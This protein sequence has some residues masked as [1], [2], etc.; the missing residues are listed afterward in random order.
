MQVTIP[1][2]ERMTLQEDSG[3]TTIFFSTVLRQNISGRSVC[4]MNLIEGHEMPR[5][6]PRPS[7]YDTTN[8]VLVRSLKT[9]LSECFG[10]QIVLDESTAEAFLDVNDGQV[11]ISSTTNLIADG[12]KIQN[13]YVRVCHARKNPL[14]TPCRISPRTVAAALVQVFNLSHVLDQETRDLLQ[15]YQPLDLGKTAL[16]AAATAPASTPDLQAANSDEPPS[17]TPFTDGESG[18]TNKTSTEDTTPSCLLVDDNEVNL[19]VR[20]PTTSALTEHTHTD[21]TLRTGP[22]RVCPETWLPACLRNQR[23]SRRRGVQGQRKRL[24][25]CIHGLVYASARRLRSNEAHTRDRSTDG[26]AT[27]KDRCSVGLRHG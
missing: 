13:P 24:R 3:D 10:V 12:L 1:L 19:K 9:I 6:R 15:I 26:L 21:N 18:D 7:V 23:R 4:I 27:C 25:H 16:P 14:L 20:I 22:W 2:T 8:T 5:R 11:F 17:N